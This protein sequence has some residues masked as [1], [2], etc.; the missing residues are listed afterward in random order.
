[1]VKAGTL[2]YAFLIMRRTIRNMNLYSQPVMMIR[3]IHRTSTFKTSGKLKKFG[4]FI[5]VRIAEERILSVSS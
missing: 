3:S 2:K 5:S 4:R 1:M